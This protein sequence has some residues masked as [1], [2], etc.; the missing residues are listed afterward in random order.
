V[1]GFLRNWVFTWWTSTNGG[2]TW[3]LQVHSGAGI[4]EKIPRAG[5]PPDKFTGGAGGLP[6]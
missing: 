6:G 1:A 5:V 4:G 2:K 3:R